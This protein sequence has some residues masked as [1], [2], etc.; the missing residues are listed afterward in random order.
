MVPVAPNS[1]TVDSASLFTSRPPTK[2][3]PCLAMVSGPSIEGVSAACAAI[4]S[5]QVSAKVRSEV[6][7]IFV[8][9][10]YVFYR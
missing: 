7:F 4:G 6:F 3:L 9:S 5:A 1:G 10:D 2:K 8:S